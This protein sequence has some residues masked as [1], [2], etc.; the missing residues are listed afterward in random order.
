MKQ[1]YLV[2]GDTGEAVAFVRRAEA[3]T[4]ARAFGLAVTPMPL[5]GTCPTWF[6]DSEGGD[7]G[8]E[9]QG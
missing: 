3:E 1:I 8:I 7:D 2:A 9:S 5:I 6:E 4:M